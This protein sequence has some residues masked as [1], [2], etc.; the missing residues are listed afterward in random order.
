MY[1]WAANNV[2]GKLI[3]QET[4]LLKNYLFLKNFFPNLMELDKVISILPQDLNELCLVHLIHK[5]V[6]LRF[7]NACIFVPSD[8]VA[9]PNSIILFRV[10]SYYF[11]IHELRIL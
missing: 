2:V 6:V 7:C 5:C 3:T 1:V 9:P 8:Q 11:L 10:L 4:L